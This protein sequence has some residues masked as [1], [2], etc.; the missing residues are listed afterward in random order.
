[1]KTK[2][3]ISRLSDG[4]VHSGASLA[5]ELGVSRTAVWKQVGRAADKG[6][7]I[8][9]IR[10]K[11]YRLV[12]PVDLLDSDR[13]RAILPQHVSGRLR[14]EVRESVDSTN[15]EVMRLR[16]AGSDE[17]IVCLSDKQTAGRG[18]R[19]KAWQS[20]EGENIYLSMGLMLKGG[21]ASL[22]G[23]SLVVG[24][25]IAETLESLGL[26]SVGL[27][28]PNDLQFDGRK[29]AGILIELQGELEGAAQVVVGIGL[30]VHMKHAQGV[31]QAWTS[32]D[33][34]TGGGGSVWERNHIAAAL[35]EHVLDAVDSFSEHGF[36]I[37]RDRWQQRDVFK[38]RVLQSVQGSHRGIGQGIND[39][40][41]YLLETSSGVEAIHAGEISLRVES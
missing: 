27:K 14:L 7:R 12:D 32:M 28:W 22:E 15:A 25:A 18:R 29:L 33:L 3:L 40:G 41:H 2:A 4:L 37:F 23:L 17:L 39:I 11:G 34:A 30:N 24:V 5:L 21:F 19:G 10:G 1:M 20:P 13:V 38:N 9:T 31:D 26:E 6:Y 35:I 16:A 36:G 8:E